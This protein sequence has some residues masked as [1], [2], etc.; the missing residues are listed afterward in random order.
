MALCGCD[1]TNSDR[2]NRGIS[3]TMVLTH[4]NALIATF[5]SFRES[6]ASSNSTMLNQ[7]GSALSR[8]LADPYQ[9]AT[10]GDIYKYTKNYTYSSNELTYTIVGDPALRIPAPLNK[11]INE[12]DSILPA[13]GQDFTLKG[14]ITDPKGNLLDKFSGEIV[15]RLLGSTQKITLPPAYQTAKDTIPYKGYAPPR[16]VLT[17]VAGKVENG[18]FSIKFKVPQEAKS[19]FGNGLQIAL[20]AFSPDTR[21]G[22]GNTFDIDFDPQEDFAYQPVKDVTA[23]TIELLEYIPSSNAISISVADDQALNLSDSPFNPGL[24]LS[25]DGKIVP[26]ASGFTRR[27]EYDRPAYTTNL[28]LPTLNDGLHYASVEVADAAGN[29]IKKSLSFIIGA[30]VSATLQFD[31]EVAIS[32]AC[33]KIINAT[34]DIPENTEL[35][36]TDSR[37]EIVTRIPCVDGEFNWNLK[38]ANGQRV[39]SGLYHG[40]ARGKSA[41]RLFQTAEI[42]IPVI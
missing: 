35:I 18:L 3:E 13:P 11:I 27:L 38:D 25:V 29:S 4:P 24:T 28:F 31:D 26:Q 16:E 22:A 1:L 8:Q 41:G 30:N 7:L 21:A 15:G 23:P 32:E 6:Y 37:G 42:R 2:G 9:V 33:V 14:R 10:I 34:T 40:V 39:I 5:T 19:H 20:G 17:M 12:G 36:V